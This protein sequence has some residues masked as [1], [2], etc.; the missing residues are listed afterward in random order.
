V[1]A[2]YAADAP[3]RLGEDASPDEVREALAE[4]ALAGGTLTGRFGR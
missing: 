1:F 4:H 2:L 3:L